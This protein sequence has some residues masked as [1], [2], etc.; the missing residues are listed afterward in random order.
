M[1]S[2]GFPD[3]KI[4][5]TGLTALLLQIPVYDS[6]GR[7]GD[8]IIGHDVFYPDDL[9]LGPAIGPFDLVDLQG[10]GVGFEG[11]HD[12]IVDVFRVGSVG[13]W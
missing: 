9:D 2:S 3:G 4:S 1:R 10:Y 12:R 13:G 8:I 6:D 7:D 11:D 5:S